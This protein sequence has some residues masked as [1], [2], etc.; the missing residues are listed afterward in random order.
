MHRLDLLP[1]CHG[2]R[3]QQKVACALPLHQRHAPKLPTQKNDLGDLTG[4]QTSRCVAEA[5]HQSPPKSN[6]D[7]SPVP[8][9][10]SVRHCFSCMRAPPGYV[11]Y[12]AAAEPT[13]RVGSSPRNR[14]RRPNESSRC[15]E[16]HGVLVRQRPRPAPLELARG[17][18]GRQTRSAIRAGEDTHDA[19][20]Y[21]RSRERVQIFPQETD[22]AI[23]GLR[24][25]S[26]ALEQQPLGNTLKQVR[27]LHCI[28]SVPK[29]Q[30]PSR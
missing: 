24:T 14:P 27:G 6:A 9:H 10:P 28:R 4:Q 30:I 20:M 22:M 11:Q 26:V 1:H 7:R 12:V 18:R 19:R 25:N 13:G 29:C 2:S 8:I 17:P 3:E 16:P 5:T 15:P 21:V 23:G